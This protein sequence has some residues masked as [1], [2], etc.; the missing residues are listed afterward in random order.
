M[1]T[2]KIR[3]C[4]YSTNGMPIIQIIVYWKLKEIISGVSDGDEFLFINIYRPY[5]GK[6][7]GHRPDGA[8]ITSV[9]LSINKNFHRYVNRSVRKEFYGHI[10]IGVK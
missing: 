3:S 10:N 1:R 5:K 7:S 8:A 9:D 6:G 2:I 4:N